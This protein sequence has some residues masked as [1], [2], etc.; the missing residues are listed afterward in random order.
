MNNRSSDKMTTRKRQALLFGERLR[1]VLT[2][3]E[4]QSCDVAKAISTDESTISHILAGRRT[5]CLENLRKIVST[6]K[7]D[8][9][10]TLWLITGKG[11]AGWINE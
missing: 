9:F 5:P 6:L 2:S 8:P 1:H 11:A 4:V 3:K 7:L 10:E